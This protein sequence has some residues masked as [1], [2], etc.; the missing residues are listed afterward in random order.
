MVN[1]KQKK[2]S[3][4]KE[5]KKWSKRSKQLLV[6]CLL[7]AILFAISLSVLLRNITKTEIVSYELV[8]QFDTEYIDDDSLELGTEETQQEGVNGNKKSYYEEESYLISGEVIN[9]KFVRDEITKEPVK[10][11]VKRGTRRWQY[12]ICSDGS[13]RYF[14]DEQFQDKNIGFTHSSK[15]FCA[16]NSQGNAVGLADNPPSE[17]SSVW[18]DS[19]YTPVYADLSGLDYMSKYDNFY[20][21]TSRYESNEE[22]VKAAQ[23]RAEQSR[24]Q[25]YQATV[26]ACMSEAHNVGE[27]LRSQLNVMGAMG[28][29]G[30]SE[31]VALKNRISQEVDSAYNS[32]MHRNGY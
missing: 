4:K 29:G 27:R 1:K 2:S 26:N 20:E 31:Y 5:H 15:D 23:E 32:C 25:A 12:M 18:S 19:S 22:D 16:E 13:Y 9:K 8:A 28:A 24:Q 11:I 30:S 14:T 7:A 21:E 10:K 3:A 6:I 17:Y